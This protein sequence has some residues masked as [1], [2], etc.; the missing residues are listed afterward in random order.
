MKKFLSIISIISFLT[1]PVFAKTDKM[2]SEY[3]KN[4]KHFAIMNPFAE[5]LVEHAIK[6]ALK[7]ETNAKFKV[8]FAAYTLSS[9]KKGIFKSIDIEGNNIIVQDIPLPYVH[10][11]SITDYNYIDYK[12]SPPIFKSDMKFAYNLLLSEDSI[13]TALTRKEYNKVLEKVN[14]VAYPLFVIKKVSTKILNNRIYIIIDYNFPIS[15]SKN[16]RSFYASSLFEVKNGEIIAKDVRLDS[17]YKNISTRKV[18]NLINLL[19]PL[20]FM[21]ELLDSKKCNGKIENVNIID[22]QVKVDGKIYVKEAE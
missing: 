20:D 2:S 17:I 7:K 9:L 4:K 14:N 8:K 22:N 10:L 19:N 15:P 3:L 13:N 11:Q 6:N 5:S 18:T 12:S 21:L 16:D 1:L